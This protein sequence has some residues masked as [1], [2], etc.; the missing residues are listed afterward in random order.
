MLRYI[1][2]IIIFFPLTAIGQDNWNQEGDLED[3]QVIIEK[4][5]KLTYHKSI[6]ILKST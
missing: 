3:S 5:V 2:F 1:L 6:G 4:T